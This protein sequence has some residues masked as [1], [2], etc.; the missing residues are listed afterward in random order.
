MNSTASFNRL[1]CLSLRLTVVPPVFDRFS[2]KSANGPITMTDATFVVALG[3]FGNAGMLWWAA[4][5]LVP[6]V[7]H[8]W[9]R[10]KFAEVPWAAMEYL[11]AA[12]RNNAR[13][14]RIQ[15]IALLAVRILILL[16]LALALADPTVSLISGWGPSVAP[17]GRTHTILVMDGSYSMGS[18]QSAAS[19]AEQAQA[20]ASEI[21]QRSRQRDG[22]SLVL[23]SQPARVLIRGPARDAGDVIAE[24]ESLTLPHA[25]ADLI[26]TLERITEIVQSTRRDFPRLDQS[27]VYFFTDLG[28]NTWQAATSPEGQ[29]AVQRLAQLATIR[30]IDLGPPATENLAI[31][32]LRAEQTYAIVGRQE[33]LEATIRNFGQQDRQAHLVELLVDGR[34]IDQ[35]QLDVGAGDDATIAF[36]YRFDD[37]QDHAVEVRLG[38][39]TL[40]VDNHRYLSVPVQSAL[41][42]LCVGDKYGEARNVALALDPKGSDSSGVRTRII[43][44][45]ELLETDLSSY[46]CVFLC[47]VGG[48]GQAE[49]RALH[50]LLREGG[51]LVIFLGDQVQPASYNQFLGQTPRLLPARLDG[52]VPEGQY[53]FDPRE[54]GHPI[55]SPFR[56]F[57]QSGLLTTPIW[58]YIRL[59]L[60]EPSQAEVAVWLDS[61]DPA[62]VEESILQGRSILVATSPSE[63]SVDRTPWSAL[64]TWPSFL[65]LVQEMLAWAVTDKFRHRNVLVGEELASSIRDATTNLAVTVAL[66]EQTERVPVAVD[67]QQGRW[68]YG[69]TMQSGM[70]R[71]QYDP[72]AHP[73]ELFAVN[74][75]TRESDPRRVDPAQLP[76]QWRSAAA[77]E[78]VPMATIGAAG[79]AWPLFRILLGIVL[80]LLLLESFLAWYSGG[81]KA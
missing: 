37:A 57:P 6:I 58:K 53:R 70:Y 48:L 42:V 54:Y 55:V 47:N 5:A 11:L 31:T 50:D 10:R 62:I 61:G 66:G 49:S 29:T 2:D 80:C 69:E 7:I 3:S 33:R 77:Y 17:D 51:G 32:S 26:E 41:G 45:S 52:V 74:V 73:A 13:R 28:Q 59:E 4:A 43:N 22:F 67:G 34:T 38:K 24:I 63:P 81:A 68:S 40:D 25:G 9:S 76:A 39:D 64:S 19:G 56:G 14:L 79:A 71:A 36:S 44:D 75:D 35:S 27:E 1:A 78:N 72:P 12:V 23:M 16:V 65:P 8:L 15:Q 21:V 18:G 20:R 60:Y 46:D 30:L